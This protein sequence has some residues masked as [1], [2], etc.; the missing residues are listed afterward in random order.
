MRYADVLLMYAE[1]RN[2]LGDQATAARYIQMVRNR[3]R[4]PNREAEFAAMSQ[5]Q[6]REVIARERFLELA[7]EGKR[8]D[9]L[10]RWG[11]LSNPAKL[12]ELRA[13]DPEFNGYAPGREWLPIPQAEMDANP[14]L[15][16][17]PSY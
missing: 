10:R 14:L 5:A 8:F 2:E 17:N 15:Q 9:D 16:Q 1:T 7:G 4:L 13:C 3:A 11:W 6:L 12:A